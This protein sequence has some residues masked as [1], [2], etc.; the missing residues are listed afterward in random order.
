M[1]ADILHDAAEE[2][3]DSLV[4]YPLENYDNLAQ[5]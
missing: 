4:E 1:I 2:I 3:R 5:F